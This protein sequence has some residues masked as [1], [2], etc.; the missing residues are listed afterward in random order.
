MRKYSGSRAERERKDLTKIFQEMGL[1][2]PVQ[3]NLKIVD[4]S[5][6]TLDLDTETFKPYKKPNDTPAYINAESNHPPAIIKQIPGIVET[7][8]SNL[9]ATKQIFDEATPACG[10]LLLVETY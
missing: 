2:I 4:Y 1:K 8:I 3:T 9:S 7:R 10:T 6:I 5:D